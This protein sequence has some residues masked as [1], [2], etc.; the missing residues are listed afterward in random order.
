MKTAA[1]IDAAGDDARAPSGVYTAQRFSR[2]SAGVRKQA[3]PISAVLG[4]FCS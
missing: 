2:R 1:V 4:R 3:I